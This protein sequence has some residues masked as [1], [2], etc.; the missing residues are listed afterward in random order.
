ML[1]K[2]IIYKK[3]INDIFFLIK[4]SRETFIKKKYQTL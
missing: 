4:V 2:Y 3:I 1:P